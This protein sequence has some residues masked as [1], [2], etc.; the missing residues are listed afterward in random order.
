[1]LEALSDI[2]SCGE[3]MSDFEWSE[4][5]ISED[6][7]I[8]SDDDVTEE[9]SGEC[10]SSEH[11]SSTACGSS[12]GPRLP[13]QS[14]KW[15]EVPCATTQPTLHYLES[16]GPCL[17]AGE[18]FKEPEDYFNL[19]FSSDILELMVEETNIYA[20]LLRNHRQMTPR[21]RLQNWRDVSVPELKAFIGLV[22][23][24]G[25]IH[26]PTL[27]DYWSTDMTANIPFFSQVKNY[28]QFLG[29]DQMQMFMS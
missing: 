13:A 10:S 27:Q 4:S 28:T 8:D 24:M 9:G 7:A 29:R 14:I 5:S 25:I 1:M 15:Q 19:F 20:Q 6:E 17:P 21:S 22:L 23:N 3:D 26:V 2:D 16:P 18:T 12:S 11:N